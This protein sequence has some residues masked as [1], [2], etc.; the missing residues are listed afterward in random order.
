MH[1]GIIQPK[2]VTVLLISFINSSLALNRT[3]E[4][5]ILSCIFVDA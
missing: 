1:I 5:Y 2:L 3:F 4:S